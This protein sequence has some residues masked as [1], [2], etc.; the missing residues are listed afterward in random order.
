MTAINENLFVSSA[1][2]HLCGF[3]PPSH[4]QVVISLW[5][6]ALK[7]WLLISYRVLKHPYFLVFYFS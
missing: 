7:Y 3:S 4:I 6:N 1:R 2:L 5:L